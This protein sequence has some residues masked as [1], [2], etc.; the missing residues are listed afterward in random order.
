MGS[1]DPHHQDRAALFF[2]ADAAIPY[3]VPGGRFR[4]MYYWDSYFTMLGLMQSGRPELAE[5]MVRDF[6]YLI[7]TFGHVPNGARTYYLSRS[8]PPFY[9]E[10]V[11]LLSAADP[12]AAF[13]RYLPPTEA[14]VRFLDARCVRS[15][16]GC[17]SIPRRHA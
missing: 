4:E 6:A 2:A 5:D 8:Q 15:A 14:R 11:G 9:F 10:M 17:G 12:P 1:A 13:G 7:D 3:V 16:S